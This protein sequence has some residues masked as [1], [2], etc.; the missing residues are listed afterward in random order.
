MRLASPA[1]GMRAI[2]LL[3]C[4]AAPTRAFQLRAHKAT[5]PHLAPSWRAPINFAGDATRVREAAP[6]AR[7]SRTPLA[8]ASVIGPQWLSL[9]PPL[10]TLVASVALKQVTLAMLIG[11]WTGALLL[12]GGN[13]VVAFLR[14]FD[15]YLVGAFLSAEHAGVVLFTLLLGGCIGL[16]QRSGGALG[17]AGLVQ[18]FF[19]SRRKGLL[20]TIGLGGLVFFDDYSSIL[21]VGNSLRPLVRS[22]KI[23]TAKFAFVAHTV[24]VCVASMSPISSWVGMQIGFIGGVYET[25]GGP[26]RSADPFS[27]FLATL[28][29]RFLPLCMLVFMLINAI[30]G[31]DFGPMLDEER[32]AL[33]L[34]DAPASSSADGER[35]AAPSPD[36]PLD[37]P[38]G[39]PLRAR[40]ALLPFGAVMGVAF[41]GMIAQGLGA[42]AQLPLATRPAPTLVNALRYAD[43]VSALIWGSACGWFVALGLAMQQQL[44]SLPDAME[45]WSSGMKEVLEPAF[46]LL[47]AWAL[48]GVIEQVGTATYLAAALQG[49]LPAWLLPATISVLCYAISF[50]T[51]SAIGTMAITFPLV[52]PIAANLG[53]GSAEYLHRCFGALMGGSLFGNLCSP[54]SDTTI[55]AVLAT[56][57]SLPVHVKT[58]VVYTGFVGLVSLVFADLAVGL[59]LYGPGVAM[60]VC[61]GVMV[62]GKMLLGSRVQE[63]KEKPG[64]AREAR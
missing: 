23:A 20:S 56:Q 39:T 22:V 50:A 48:G 26:W 28:Q 32:A 60:L 6:P 34:P 46:I 40:N 24:G 58:S 38:V 25:L 44:L 55:L 61:T 1:G 11:I 45:A 19:D 41:G 9:L 30:S 17:L 37:P 4:L 2:C 33:L 13:P 10:A 36:G 47:L 16:V 7:R 64:G 31:R 18:R 54:I 27:G 63:Q 8:V 21:I 42:I 5:L 51:G 62:L 43:S 35:A 53:G 57:C 12:H 15:H 59:R 14:T 29:Y 52:G 3:I 49:G